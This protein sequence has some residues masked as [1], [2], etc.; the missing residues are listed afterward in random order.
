MIWTYGVYV[1]RLHAAA[2]LPQPRAGCHKYY[3]GSSA[4]P[5]HERYYQHRHGYKANRYVR[6]FGRGLA[7]ELYADL[8]RF[9][10]RGPA[11]LLEGLVALA[12]REHG[13]SCHVGI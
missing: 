12:L 13:H 11:E 1:V 4:L 3:I 9:N 7:R 2:P 6:R 5:D 10:D 8:P